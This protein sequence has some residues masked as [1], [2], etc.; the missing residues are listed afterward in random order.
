MVIMVDGK[1]LGAPTIRSKIADGKAQITGNFTQE[2]AERIA[3]G[4]NGK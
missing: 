3:K 2:E 1:V 4:I